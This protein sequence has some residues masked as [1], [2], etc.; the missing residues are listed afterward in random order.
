M[1][2]VI[3]FSSVFHKWP[4]KLVQHMQKTEPDLQVIALT[5]DNRVYD[6]LTA[7][8]GFPFK[9]IW[10]LNALEKEWMS[11]PFEMAQLRAVEEKIGADIP[12]RTLI[13][14]KN[15]GKGWIEGAILYDTALSALLKDHQKQRQYFA[16]LYSFLL[17][18]YEE[19]KPSLSL[20]YA[21]AGGLTYS[22]AAVSRHFDIP[23]VQFQGAR[24]DNYRI[25]DTSI[26]GML[27]PVQQMVRAAKDDPDLLRPYWADAEEKLAR[28]RASDAKPSIIKYVA[29]NRQKSTKLL[30]LLR[31]TLGC[32][33]RAGRNFVSGGEQDLRAKP[34]KQKF[35]YSVLCKLPHRRAKIYKYCH[36]FAPFDGQDFVFFPLHLDPEA[37]TLVY[38]PYHT[39]QLAVIENIA[40]QLPLSSHL[41]VKEHPAMIGQRPVAFYQRIE[42]MPN[43]TMVYPEI[44]GDLLVQKAS[45]VA[46][47]TGTAGWE[48][49]LL[50]KPLVMMGQTPYTA[51]LEEGFVYCPDL[52][53]LHDAFVQA[54]A[55]KPVSD[56][57][58]LRFIA[59]LLK[60]GTP[61]PDPLIWGFSEEVYQR[62]IE[63]SDTVADK[64]L[65]TAKRELLS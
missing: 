8:E 21:V 53:Q 6:D 64:L 22:I 1:N 28:L 16:G 46:T 42:A 65:R 33:V 37:S 17:N 5:N 39:N 43:V 35:F 4:L 9:A 59:A 52:T 32:L 10:N 48:A 29:Q 56:E 51:A 40:K 49:L 58:L 19:H 27:E 13:A 12:L 62:Y 7:L 34:E 47:I 20:V 60:V 44:A 2:I 50:G 14:D 24:I 36:D 38:S 15:L 63:V 26:E 25:L 54:K 30:P 45:I 57:S 11:Q 61:I 31:A 18:L 23:A 41:I 3:F 55:L